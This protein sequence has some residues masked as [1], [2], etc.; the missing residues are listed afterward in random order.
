MLRALLGQFPPTA[1]WLWLPAAPTPR[2]SGT[3]MW[4]GG[5]EGAQGTGPYRK[6]LPTLWLQRED[7]CSLLDVNSENEEHLVPAG[8]RPCQHVSRTSSCPFGLRDCAVCLQL[9]SRHAPARPR[10]A[11]IAAG[12]AQLQ[13]N[14][15]PEPCPAR[16]PDP[17]LTAS[18]TPQERHSG[19]AQGSMGL[20]AAAPRAPHS[21]QAGG[22]SVLHSIYSLHHR[23][24]NL[25]PSV[26]AFAGALQTSSFFFISMR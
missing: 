5:M 19:A 15:R 20:T 21:P 10:C 24:E 14:L 16:S 7:N 13:P 26:R 8:W 4:N 2:V 12:A 9:C 17:A 22:C 1:C 25:I 11:L 6:G 18:G 23:V 3:A